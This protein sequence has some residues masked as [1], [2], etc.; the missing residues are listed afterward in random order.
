MARQRGSGRRTGPGEYMYRADFYCNNGTE[1]LSPGRTRKCDI[2]P[3][4][5]EFRLG[6]IF[7]CRQPRILIK[8]YTNH[9]CL[10]LTQAC[11]M[12]NGTPASTALLVRLVAVV[13]LYLFIF[14]LSCAPPTPANASILAHGM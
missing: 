9:S 10:I 6:R 12:A 8:Q 5:G 11:M 1:A 2:S 3:I 13:E 14:A 4:H 7:I